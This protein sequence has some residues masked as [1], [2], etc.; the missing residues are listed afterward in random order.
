M[1]LQQIARANI[2]RQ[3]LAPIREAGRF[4]LVASLFCI[5]LVV[6]VVCGIATGIWVLL[7]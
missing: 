2:E 1:N 6:G 7:R 3:E 5:L 4:L